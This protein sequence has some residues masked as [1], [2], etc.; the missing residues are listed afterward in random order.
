METT[1][2]HCSSALEISAETLVTL[3]GASH[4]ECPVCAGAVAV[5]AESDGSEETSLEA[6]P[7]QATSFDQVGFTCPHCA[8]SLELDGA[9]IESLS[10][11][12]GFDCPVCGNRVGGPEEPE[13]AAAP[14]PEESAPPP[15]VAAS[16]APVASRATPLLGAFRGLN[17]NLVILGT[18]ALLT[19]G[20]VGIY[21]ASR[22]GGSR[23]N[24][25][26]EV[27]NEIIKNKFFTDL[28]ASGATT[29]QELEAM[30]EIKPLGIG[31]SGVSLEKHTW[32]QALALAKRTGSRIMAIEPPKN[33]AREPVLG[34]LA[35]D[36]PDLRGSTG[37]AMENGEPRVIDGPNI[38]PVKTLDRPR[39]A[40]LSW[41]PAATDKKDRHSLRIKSITPKL[42]NA[43][44]KIDDWVKVVVEYNN[45]GPN[46]VLIWAMPYTKG[47]ETDGFAY[48]PSDPIAKGKG[49]IERSFSVESPGEVDEVRVT[50]VDRQT[51]ETLAT[52][53]L[54]V[55][56]RWEPDK[57]IID[58]EILSVRSP[59]TLSPAKEISIPVKPGEKFT[60]N[61]T[62]RYKTPEPT[63]LASNLL[64]KE[65][66][67]LPLEFLQ[68]L[69]AN[70]STTWHFDTES[71]P[72][73]QSVNGEGEITFDLTGYAPREKG[74]STFKLNLG[75]FD[76]ETWSTKTLK[77]YNVTLTAD[78]PATN[79][80][81]Q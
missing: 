27:T 78:G 10:A 37:W 17:R 69:T 45:L 67:I 44:L 7:L 62:A 20:G 50:M 30:A 18:L 22:K 81:S 33:A 77:F 63:K 43:R 72:G 48:D 2:L 61:L 39:K 31:F 66:N 11:G 13:P 70:H 74:P 25:R 36:Y 34:R 35:E 8:Q 5:P 60:V 58:V 1:C 16:P 4:F 76:K 9:A 29:A 52:A 40:F 49:D 38:N 56:A 68:E 64:L 71:R 57:N 54:P 24:T 46:E 12:G 53:F 73:Y 51:K 21:L 15:A 19:L 26:R 55:Q 6:P 79:P 23:Y 80:L 41:F 32:E 3:N 28:I 47:E 75:L 42:T 59:A 65:A 14:L